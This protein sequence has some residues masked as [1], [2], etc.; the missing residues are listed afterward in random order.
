MEKPYFKND[1]VS[2]GIVTYQL[3]CISDFTNVKL[4]EALLKQVVEK[5]NTIKAFLYILGPEVELAKTLL[6]AADVYAWSRAPVFKD[7]DS[8][9]L[10][11]AEKLV[12]A[13]KRSVVCDLEIGKFLF[14][15][16]KNYTGGQ[17]VIIPLMAGTRLSFTNRDLRTVAH[18]SFLK[19]EYI[20]NYK[21]VLAENPEIEV[22]M[23]NVVAA[24]DFDGKL[25]IMSPEV[26]Q[27]FKPTGERCF[28]I[29]GFAE[30]SQIC[31]Y[32][33]T[34]NG[35]RI[36]FP[37]DIQK[38]W[39]RALLEILGEK[40]M[41]A[42]VAKRVIRKTKAKYYVMIPNV[43]FFYMVQLGYGNNLRRRI[44]ETKPE[45]LLDKTEVNTAHQKVLYDYLDGME[46]SVE[47]LPLNFEM[48]HNPGF[49]RC[50]R[51]AAEKCACD[52][53]GVEEEEFLGK[54]FCRIS[55]ELAME[56]LWPEREFEY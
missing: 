4:D 26:R 8:E 52:E 1:I 13:I 37:S 31:E 14:S 43:K 55:V 47:D 32:M 12:K 49:M 54:T 7:S 50:A 23:S 16:Y 17:P 53:A 51:F 9:G 22:E 48:I 19:F 11:V 34:G 6:N 28:K 38:I 21:Y 5:L 42:I 15:Y 45:A 18:N 10:K 33:F 30:K 25:V 46:L 20:P 27:A 39:T 41:V 3:L 44:R 56:D 40:E 29:L 36:V 35:S 24:H 2:R